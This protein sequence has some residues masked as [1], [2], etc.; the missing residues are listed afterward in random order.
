MVKRKKKENPF[1]PM[2]FTWG[3]LKGQKITDPIDDEYLE[4]MADTGAHIGRP[5]MVPLQMI[6]PNILGPAHAQLTR[7]HT[8][9]KVHFG[10]KHIHEFACLVPSGYWEY[11][12]PKGIFSRPPKTKQDK[13]LRQ[14][15]QIMYPH[16]FQ[17]TNHH[18][19][20]KKFTAHQEMMKKF[21]LTQ[22][23]E[24]DDDPKETV[25]TDD[26]SQTKNQSYHKQYLAQFEL[27]QNQE[28]TDDEKR[29][30]VTADEEETTNQSM[31]TVQTNRRKRKRSQKT[32]RKIKKKK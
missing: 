23:E 27:P 13:I 32:T 8:K 25:L 17:H 10:K 6:Y 22:D 24:D 2:I 29:A 19:D 5:E 18:D 16:L 9:T 21:G 7:E 15:I 31:F 11:L 1:A 3:K 28:D 4:W 14:T 12:V 30:E 26:E 20:S